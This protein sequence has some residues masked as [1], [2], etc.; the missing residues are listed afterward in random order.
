[1]NWEG[2]AKPLSFFLPRTEGALNLR[3]SIVVHD[4]SGATDPSATGHSV[5]GGIG[6]IPPDE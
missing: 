6:G 4:K 5:G 3:A 1:M 2:M